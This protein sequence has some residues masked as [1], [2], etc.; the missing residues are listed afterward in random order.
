MAPKLFTKRCADCRA[1]GTRRSRPTGAFA[2]SSGRET[3]KSQ[4]CF[5][6]SGAL[7]RGP[8]PGA[9]PEILRDPEVTA[10]MHGAVIVM[11]HRRLLGS[12][13]LFNMGRESGQPARER[14]RSSRVVGRRPPQGT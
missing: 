10:P 8:L 7:P 9:H 11:L 13:C 12:V 2:A 14:I 6:A 5:A 1:V 4:R 3:P